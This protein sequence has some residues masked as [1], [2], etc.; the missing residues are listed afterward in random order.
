M[1]QFFAL[2][3]LL[4]FSIFNGFA[5]DTPFGLWK[6]IDDETGEAKSYVRIYE[7]DGKLFGKIDKLL[8]DPADSKCDLCPG[9]KKDQLLVGMEIIYN[10]KK[11]GNAWEDGKILKADDGKIYK[12]R[13]W[14]ENGKLMVRG[15]VGFFYKTQ[16]WEWVS[17]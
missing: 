13:I 16:K 7:K 1:K 11:D 12:G 2:T 14:V 4:I 17:K 8:Q 15:Y 5:Q 6:T 10:M 9:D 3:T